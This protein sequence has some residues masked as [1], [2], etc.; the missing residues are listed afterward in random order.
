MTLNILRVSVFVLIIFFGN[1]F[2]QTSLRAKIDSVINSQS[3]IKKIG[4]VALDADSKKLIYSK[5]ADLP[6]IPASTM[7]LFTT[8][9]ILDLLGKNFPLSLKVLARE[10]PRDGKLNCDLIIKGFGNPFFTDFDLDTLAKF[11]YQSGVREINGNIIGDDSYFD[12]NYYREHWVKHERT[13]VTTP[14]VSAIVLNRN[15]VRVTFIP[16]KNSGNGFTI[17]YFP[18]SEFYETNFNAKI[19]RRYSIPRIKIET[20]PKQIKVKIS[21]KIRKRRYPYS[22]YAFVDN[23]PLFTANLLYEKL[24]RLGININ[25]APDV[26][27]AS[28][29]ESELFSV[30]TRLEN[31]VEKANKESDNFLAEMLFKTLGAEYCGC[32]GNSFYAIQAIYSYLEKKRIDTKGIE[33]LDGSGISRHNKLTAKAVT[34]LLS[35]VYDDVEIF[36]V[37]YSSLAAAGVDGT[38]EERLNGFGLKNN[39][40]GKTGTLNGVSALSGY[41]TTQSGKNVI[42]SI[43][44]NFNKRGAEYWREVQDE[45]VVDIATSY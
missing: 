18:E 36:N 27:I 1:V 3:G 38:L 37:F 16:N 19:T 12:K 24:S 26:G 31:V 15:E 13:N 5:N 9:S 23:P 42:I 22:Y 34:D 14:P 30:K 29:K 4:I 17:Q 25:G 8:A 39:F 28:G 2:P 6:V 32:Q 35:A 45:I 44:I 33:I 7:K 10:L 43:L 21:G 11:I 40:H 20:T 41:F